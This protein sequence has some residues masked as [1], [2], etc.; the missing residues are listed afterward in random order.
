M[1]IPTVVVCLNHFVFFPPLEI[2]LYGFDNKRQLERVVNVLCQNVC[3]YS[4][5]R[6]RDRLGEEQFLALC[7][8]VN[9]DPRW[10]PS[11]GI[12]SYLSHPQNE[13]EACLQTTHIPRDTP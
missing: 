13:A 1:G 7:F 12:Y 6:W 3:L 4:W 5:L 2:L 8:P 11:C 10:H 9:S